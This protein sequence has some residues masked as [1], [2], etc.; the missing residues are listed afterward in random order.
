MVTRDHYRPMTLSTFE[1]HIV[2]SVREM[3]D[4]QIL[5]LVREK[6]TSMPFDALASPARSPARK[7]A[8]RAAE[9]ELPE[10]D[11]V[12]AFVL[13]SDG[14]AV[15]DVSERLD[16]PK[17]RASSILRKLRDQR[18]IAQG[19]TRRFARYAKTKKIARA[20]SLRDRGTR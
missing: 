16:I 2:S 13:A 12:L 11:R 14:V 15:K 6:L 18:E 3:P 20:A 8:S 17:T 9:P 10:R 4:D 1:K 19:G 7:R 5:D